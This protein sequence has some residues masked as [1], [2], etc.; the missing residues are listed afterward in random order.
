MLTGRRNPELGGA[1][2]YLD[3][4]G[5]NYYSDN[6]WRHGGSTIPL[7]HHDYKPLSELLAD[8]HARFGRPV[9]IAETGAEGSGR[10]AWLHY[11]AQEARAALAA[12]VPVEGI[13]VYP[14]LEY[15]GWEDE[16]HCA[17][18]LLCVPDAGGHRR[19]YAPLA[20]EL[21]RQQTVLADALRAAPLESAA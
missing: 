2:R 4:L 19:A 17:T 3:V 15:P 9:L 11:V 18:G 7:G 16:R 5:V 1:P 14:V 12:D 8:V 20:E 6:Q 10:A 21:L 13:C